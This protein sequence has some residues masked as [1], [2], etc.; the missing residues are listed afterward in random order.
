MLRTVTGPKSTSRS[1]T[2]CLKP[3]LT[4]TARTL[5]EGWI[6]ARVAHGIELGDVLGEEIVEHGADGR[7]HGE[8]GDVLPG[9]S[10]RS[11]HEIGGKGEF[12]TKQNPGG[13]SEPDLA[14]LH[15]AGAAPDRARHHA[16]EGLDRAK[17]HYQDGAG[18]DDER[19]VAR[20]LAE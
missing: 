7:D 13:E 15:L 17:T 1:T 18:L 9:G 6:S 4:G 12:E 5:R 10:D 8:L 19:D 3:S 14:P 2:N 16:Y 11:A 20:D